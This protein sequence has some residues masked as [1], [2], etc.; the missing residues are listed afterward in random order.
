MNSNGS[1]IVAAPIFI[2]G[3]PRSG[4]SLLRDMLDA[5]SNL[6]FPT[7]SHFIPVFFK[8]YGDPQTEGE[9]RRLARK[10]LKLTWIRS[11]D[12]ALEPVDFADDRSFREI[13]TRL[14]RAYARKQKKTR[15]GDKTPQ[16]VTEIPVLYALFPECKIIHVYRDGRDVALSWLRVGLDARNIFTAALSW[17]EWVSKGRRDGAALPSN[18]YFEVRYESLLA[19]PREVIKDVCEFLEEPFSEAVLRKNPL[20]RNQRRLR[21]GQ[22][23]F[24]IPNTQVVETNAQKWKTEMSPRARLLFESIAGDLLASIGY[25]VSGDSRQITGPERIMWRTHHWSCWVVDRMNSK[26]FLD[27][28]V[29]FLS[30]TYARI[31]CALGGALSFRCRKWHWP[32]EHRRERNKVTLP[33]GCVSDLGAYRARTPHSIASNCQQNCQQT[34]VEE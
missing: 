2:V 29:T 11:W 25:E 23:D 28:L 10:I 30:M 13:V 3:C 8:A 1:E 21:L 18:A 16:Y 34:A 32:N 14:Y 26:N 5:H 27:W 19:R 20:R 6:T 7:E 9:A 12:L 15:W 31:R 24:G 17:K 33:K 22:R 4:T